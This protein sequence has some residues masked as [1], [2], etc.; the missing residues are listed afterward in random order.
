MQVKTIWDFLSSKL[1]WLS[2]RIQNNNKQTNICWQTCG[3]KDPS[4]TA[5]VISTSPMEISMEVPQKATKWSAVSFLGVYLKELK[6]V[7]YVDTWV[8]VFIA[9]KFTVAKIWNQLGAHH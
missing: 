1:E 9:A 2:S 5:G 7:N 4:Y 6:L 3:K 8:P